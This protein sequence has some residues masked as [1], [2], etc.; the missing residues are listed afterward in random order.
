MSAEATALARASPAAM[1][2][3]TRKLL[4]N[5]SSTARSRAAAVSPSTPSGGL[6]APRL[7]FCS[8][9]AVR[10]SCERSRFARR[11]SR[12][13][14]K[15]AKTKTPITAMAS[16]LAVRETALFTPEASPECR[17]STE[18]NAVV[19]SGAI[20]RDIPKPI[21]T[22]AG[23]NVDQYEDERKEIQCSPEPH[24]EEHRQQIRP[25]EV[26]RPEQAERH[27]RLLAP[28]LGVDK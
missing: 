3:A 11:E 2:M 8:S 10:V 21:T 24:V 18:F 26:S 17:P 5:D 14:E 27:H 22:T 25:G 1:Y 4:T 15:V 23:K 9:I 6:A 28:V 20:T 13:A 12:V 7:D 19:V 16:R